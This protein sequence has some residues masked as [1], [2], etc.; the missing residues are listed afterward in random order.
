MAKGNSAERAKIRI[1]NAK[2]QRENERIAHEMNSGRSAMDIE[3]ER[4]AR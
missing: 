1:E 3:Y 4:M 2:R